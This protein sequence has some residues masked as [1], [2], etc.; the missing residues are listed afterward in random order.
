M[1]GE[2]QTFGTLATTPE[3]LDAAIAGEDPT[4]VAKL[5]DAHLQGDLLVMDADPKDILDVRAQV[6]AET[7]VSWWDLCAFT[8]ALDLGAEMLVGEDAM[9]KRASAYGITAKVVQL[10]P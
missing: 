10:P 8:L 6:F 3:T 4:E 7:G 5:E 9:V 2:L 1:C